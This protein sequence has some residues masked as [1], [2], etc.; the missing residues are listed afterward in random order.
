[1][2]CTWAVA[3]PNYYTPCLPGMALLIGSTWLQLARTG[4]GQGKGALAA[5]GDLASP[6]GLDVRRGGGGPARGS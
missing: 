6:M 4:R 2:F 1:M 5:R 3:K